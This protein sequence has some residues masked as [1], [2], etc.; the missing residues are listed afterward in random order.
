MTVIRRK[1]VSKDTPPKG[2]VVRRRENKNK[3]KKKKKNNNNKK[4]KK[5]KEE[6]KTTGILLKTTV[7]PGEGFKECP[8]QKG[9]RGRGRS[10]G[11]L[12]QEQEQPQRRPFIPPSPSHI[13]AIVNWTK[14]N[15]SKDGSTIATMDKGIQK[16]AVPSYNTN[17]TSSIKDEEVNAAMNVTLPTNEMIVIPQGDRPS[18]LQHPTQ[19]LVGGAT[20]TGKTTLV[21]KILLNRHA[22]FNV[23]IKNVYWYYTMPK[24]VESIRQSLPDVNFVQGTPT[25]NTI[26]ELNIQEPTI[27]VMDDMQEMVSNGKASLNVVKNIFTR[28]SHHGNL[29]VIMLVQDLFEKNMQQLARS[30]ENTFVMANSAYGTFL[31]S[32]A[33]R[34]LPSGGFSFLQWAFDR[35]KQRGPYGYLLVSTG[36]VSPCERARTSIFPGEPNT[37]FV[38]KGTQQDK[39]YLELKKHAAEGQQVTLTNVQTPEQAG[40]GILPS[41]P[42]Q[43]VPIEG[44]KEALWGKKL[45]EYHAAKRKRAQEEEAAAA[46]AW[47]PKK[48]GKKE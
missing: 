13:K 42:P 2:V 12:Q 19:C 39:R 36:N 6:E 32:L 9:G 24:S 21:Q 5:E 34:A 23:P 29:S 27:M 10:S 20:K 43:S 22:L 47:G 1:L 7:P 15:V 14:K 48:K 33:L 41:Q 26:A 38:Q 28:E 40:S 17:T 4:K 11:T 45:I 25:H 16:P 18:V 37:F 3:N 30:A 44:V 8:T 35:I 31:R 46:A